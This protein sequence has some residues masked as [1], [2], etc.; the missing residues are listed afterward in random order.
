MISETSR[1]SLKLYENK[2]LPETTDFTKMENRIWNFPTLRYTALGHLLQQADPAANGTSD[3]SVSCPANSQERRKRIR[4]SVTSAWNIIKG[5]LSWDMASATLPPVLPSGE[6]RYVDNDLTLILHSL[7]H[8]QLWNFV[9]WF[10][11]TYEV[12]SL[13]SGISDPVRLRAPNCVRR[14]QDFI[15]TL[16]DHLQSGRWWVARDSTGD[17]AQTVGL[18][19]GV[20]LRR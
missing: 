6:S 1:T 17:I 13:V 19:L 9:K 16:A 12:L 8:M 5:R 10:L 4:D 18:E 7:R 3:P 20:R 14:Q 2:Q 11:Q 15:A